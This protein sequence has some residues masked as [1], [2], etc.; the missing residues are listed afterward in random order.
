MSGDRPGDADFLARR[1]AARRKLDA[2]P[3]A[4][5]DDPAGRKAW[6]GTVYSLAEGDPAA[7]PWADLAAKPALVDWLQAHPGLGRRA[8][9]VGCGLG[10]NAEALAA[11]GWLTSAFDIAEAAVVWAK[12][13][14]PDTTVDYRCADLFEPPAEWRDGFDLVHECFTLQAM[15]GPLRTAA[16]AAVASLVAPG[17]TLLVIARSRAE[18]EP[19]GQPPWPLA[20]SELARFEALGFVRVGEHAY[21]S[22]SARGVA[23]HE[24]RFEF[25]RS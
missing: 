10:D 19:V 12:R 16:F 23:V 13:R 2:A 15:A 21:A 3:G 20:P 7:I 17:G 14:F 18:S 8:L 25:R 1:A 11:A 9:D 22:V 5:T 24:A 4:F 6:F